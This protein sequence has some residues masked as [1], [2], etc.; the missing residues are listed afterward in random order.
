VIKATSIDPSVVGA[1]GVYRHTGPARVFADEREAI[2]AVKGGTR[3]PVKP[4][5]VLVLAGVGPSGTGMEETAQLTNSLK[6]LPW[7]KHV[8]ILT[9]ARFSGLSTGACIG[10]VGPEALAGGPIGKLRDDDVL[11][12]E[13]DRVGLVGRVDLV[14]TPDG[15]LTEREATDLLATRSLH[16]DMRPHPDLPD[17]TRLWAILQ[18][19]SGGTWRG[20]VYDVDRISQ[21]IEAGMKVKSEGGE[22]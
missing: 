22:E 6:F 11:Q 3:R 4:G 13:I 10:H 15:P 5:D 16:P 21:L 9:D 1:D 12:L 2:E 17:D 20:C 7:G 19:A 18:R 8:A 14:G